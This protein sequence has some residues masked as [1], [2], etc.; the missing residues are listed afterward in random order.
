[1]QLLDGDSN[2]FITFEKYCKLFPND[3]PAMAKLI[4]SYYFVGKYEEAK[5]L[6][7]QLY[8]AHKRKKLPS[9]MKE[10]FCFDQFIWNGK[11]VMVFER[12]DEPKND[13]IV[14]HQF[15][16]LK[17]DGEID[18]QV[19]SESSIAVRMTPGNKYVLCLVRGDSYATSWN[20][21]FNDDYKYGE[22]KAAVISILNNNLAS[23]KGSLPKR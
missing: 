12:F 9:T 20:Y 5:P 15:V 3:Y 1:M 23:Q 21:I 14:K 7:A 18:Y 17:D 16:I 19:R 10:V 22:L 13:L 2:S 11:R 6:R 4:Q 8:E